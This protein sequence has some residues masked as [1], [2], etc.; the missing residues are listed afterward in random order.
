MTLS[1]D[2]RWMSAAVLGAALALA[3][4]SCEWRTGEPAYASTDLTIT[5]R[6]TEDQTYDPTLRLFTLWM[7]EK[8][9]A[10]TVMGSRD[11]PLVRWL[12]ARGKDERIAVVF[13]EGR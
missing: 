5:V 7:G 8:Q 9:G 6:V 2:L 11:L 1:L 10:V 4:Q 12:A 13:Q 3:A